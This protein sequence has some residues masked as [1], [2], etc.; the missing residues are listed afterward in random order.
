MFSNRPTDHGC[1]GSPR[2]I[3]S[4][5]RSKA[6]RWA[7]VLAL[8]PFVAIHMGA[9]P[10]KAKPKKTP[11]LKKT[12]QEATP[13]APTGPKWGKKDPPMPRFKALIHTIK[14][15]KPTVR[16][17][18]KSPN[19]KSKT[20]LTPELKAKLS[21]AHKQLSARFASMEKAIQSHFKNPRRHYLLLET[22]KPMYQPGQTIWFRSI[23]VN[24]K[25]KSLPLS[26][27]LYIYQLISPRGSVLVKRW[28]LA[29]K[30]LGWHLFKLSGNQVGGEYT[31]RAMSV[32]TRAIGF[33]K[34][35][36][37]N[38]QPPR[39]KKKLEFVR[40]AYGSGDKVQAKL[41][42]HKATGPALSN[43]LVQV[44]VRLDGRT[45]KSFK[46]ET[47]NQGKATLSFTLPK[48]LK[49]DD[50]SF[51]VLVKDAGV[52]ESITRPIPLT[53]KN[54]QVAFFPEGGS[55]VQGLP[56]RVYLK[57][58]KQIDQKPADIEGVVK[59][60][61]GQEVAKLR[62]FHD[63]IGHLTFTP[64]AGKQYTLHIT[65]PKGIQRTYPLPRAKKDGIAFQVVNDYTSQQDSVFLKV[66]STKAQSISL[67]GL[68]QEQLLA[69]QKYTLQKGTQ[70]LE[71][72][73][74]KRNQKQG[75]LRIAL[76]DDKLTPLG[77]RM[78]FRH[79]HKGL[80]FRIKL[81]KDKYRPRETV[82]ATITVTKPDGTPLKNSS[83]GLSVVD[84]T[85]LSFADDHEPNILSQ[86]FLTHQLMGKV[87]KPNFY[88][89]PKKEKAP[90]ALDMLLATASWSGDTWSDMAQG[91][92]IGTHKNFDYQGNAKTLKK[93]LEKEMTRLF[94]ARKKALKLF[95]K[96][97]KKL[98]TL[99]KNAKRP[100]PGQ[101]HRASEKRTGKKE[102]KDNRQQVV[103]VSPREA[104][105]KP[106]PKPVVHSFKKKY[107]PALTAPK[108]RRRYRRIRWRAAKTLA[109]ASRD[110]VRLYSASPAGAVYHRARHR[111]VEYYRPQ[112]P[113][114]MEFRN[115]RSF[116]RAFRNYIRRLKK[117]RIARNRARWNQILYPWPR[118]FQPCI[119]RSYRAY[120][121]K[122]VRRP[123]GR[124]YTTRRIP[125]TY[126]YASGYYCNKYTQRTYYRG[127]YRNPMRDNRET[128]LW[129]PNLWTDAQGK[130]T[131][132]FG[133][134]DKIGSFKIRV[135][136]AGSGSMGMSNQVLTSKKPFYMFAKL[137]LEVSAGDAM[138]IPLT[139][140]NESDIPLSLNVKVHTNRKLKL[141]ENPLP[142]KLNLPAGQSRT[143][144]YPIRVKARK[145]LGQLRFSAKSTSTDMGH[146]LKYQL[147]I[148]PRG[149]PK[150]ISWSG[151]LDG[152]KEQRR[153]FHLPQ[154]FNPKE[155][156][157]DI[158]LYANPLKSVLKGMDSMIREPHGCFEQVS[159]SNYPNIMILSYL[160]AN[161]VKKP[162]LQ[163]RSYRYLK[164][165]Y[166]K[167][168][169]YETPTGGF[170][171]YGRPPGHGTLTAYGIFQFTKMKEVYPGVSDTMIQRNI[172]WL[173][174]KRDG[175]GGFVQKRP[176]YSFGRSGPEIVNA[177]TT[178]ALVEA[179]SQQVETEIAALQKQA[180]TSKDP[181]FLS[182]VLATLYKA[183]PH[184]KVPKSAKKILDTLLSSQQTDGH[185]QGTK[186]SIM[187][188][189]G[190]NLKV[191]TTALA[192][193]AMIR[194][195][196]PLPKVISA[197]KW[198][199]SKR[200]AY[201][202]YGSTQATS[203]TLQALLAY[204]A[205]SRTTKSS[206]TFT[207]TLNDQ[208]IGKVNYAKGSKKELR[209]SKFTGKF[210][211]GKN[212]L[213]VHLK[214]KKSV[215]FG[216]G[217][218]Y[219]TY[220]PV[221]HPKASLTLKTTLNKQSAKMGDLAR[222]TV[223]IGNKHKKHGVYMPL[224]RIRFPGA[225]RS[226]VWQLKALKAKKK[227]A[228]FEMGPREVVLYFRALG[229][230][231]KK[232]IHLDLVARV[233]GNYNSSASVVYPY[234]TN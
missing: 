175:K 46:S 151:T 169:G 59:D 99:P 41:T 28:R 170:D 222:L 64:S 85:V 232:V 149:Y 219:F 160:K 73:L 53:L 220:T 172:Q 67:F 109:K 154:D 221:S 226:Q 62:T 91:R 90:K 223:E 123:D 179:G 44:K 70:L 105:D 79:L 192:V 196:V 194:A 22:D 201:G 131:V 27:S 218:R 146:E 30:G 77:E 32:S 65:K 200:S 168:T 98:A 12:G 35:M 58:R 129:K 164:K 10:K 206:G 181:Y 117:M 118:N 47:N 202:G 88:F 143:Y 68:Q 110:S 56:A 231:A 115:T 60:G 214:S 193:I 121:T 163:E 199:R 187:N 178:F 96:S 9:T 180:K 76:F 24:A 217:L 171:W 159:S 128:L 204:D 161:R 227:I 55:M 89:D 51:S 145:G 7:L 203:L 2:S 21:T 82:K 186:T 23:E 155:S 195:K 14:P 183:Y 122:Y 140:R 20:V 139:L 120:R 176:R 215:P 127:R 71:L 39:I 124:S 66:H 54:I 40:K 144:F 81:H 190:R 52:T 78:V 50:G 1:P 208:P 112:K 3:D 158:E 174:A 234:Y 97:W 152:Q 209:F 48:H 17:I 108:R 102:D 173:L 184:N 106:R 132:Q 210:K 156:S 157:T 153:E 191:E 63:G 45:V 19:P 18:A 133:L 34:I 114:R 36:V 83:I 230:Q 207:V 189:Y 57:A 233:T 225:L 49:T 61:L 25:N 141:M 43:H 74:P 130:V 216:F 205:Y 72:V 33:K 224:A 228:F 113:D 104:E 135:S 38:Y 15:R 42:L 126:H 150:T 134:N 86:R 11:K 116:R 177:Y 95:N 167:L 16:Q 125:Y 103:K 211:T 5:K 162:G 8:F 197:I 100:H 37:N 165:G 136:S 107:K 212:T 101:K 229:P 69:V 6:L 84:D 148:Q 92:S 119:Y 31:I 138:A 94:V 80:K 198:L 4:P 147:K 142:S 13:T 166:Q 185:F 137:P 75:V 111:Y 26:R 213:A 29:S 87:H 182:L 188:S 93:Q